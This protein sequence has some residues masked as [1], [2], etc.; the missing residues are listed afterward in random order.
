[1]G[2]EECCFQL[3]PPRALT[4]SRASLQ[5]TSLGIDYRDLQLVQGRGTGGRESK[6]KMY[7]GVTSAEGAQPAEADE[8]HLNL[9]AWGYSTAQPHC[10]RWS[11]RH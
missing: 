3:G 1:M 6:A 2:R 10:S 8:M 11:H 4:V 5:V 9:S 7:Y